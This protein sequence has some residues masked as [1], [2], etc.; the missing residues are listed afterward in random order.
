MARDPY[1]FVKETGRDKYL[2]SAQKELLNLIDPETNELKRDLARYVN[3]VVCGGKEHNTAFYK[4]GFRFVT[5]CDCGMLFVN[6]QLDDSKL[7]KSYTED[8][9]HSKW[10]D[11]LLSPAQLKYDSETRFG[12]ALRRLEKRYAKNKRGKILDVGCS[13]GLFLKLAKDRGWDPLGMEI[14]PKAVKYAREHFKLPV[15]EKLLHEVN[16]KKESFQIISLWGVLEHLAHPD[17]ILDEIHPLMSKDGTLVLLVPNGHSL[18]TRIMHAQAATFGGRNHLWY[19]SPETITKLLKR[20]GFKV[21][22]IYTQLT[23]FEE[24][25]HFLKYQNPYIPE[26]PF[27]SQEFKF[28]PKI[29]KEIESYTLKNNLGYKLI[30]FASKIGA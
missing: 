6:P 25:M 30:V 18:A 9:S 7:I 26:K 21:T 29:R 4:E 28:S 2:K 14:N 8:E 13:I 15:D 10:V 19:F 27:K 24:I 22:S 20:K 12:E 16:Y 17:K 3:C 5:C 23:Q 11:V 1:Q